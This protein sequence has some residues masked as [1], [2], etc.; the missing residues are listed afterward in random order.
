M[1]GLQQSNKSSKVLEPAVAVTLTVVVSV[2]VAAVLAAVRAFLLLLLLQLR[3]EH[4]SP[5]ET[6]VSALDV[7]TINAKTNDAAIRFQNARVCAQQGGAHRSS[8][9]TGNSAVLRSMPDAGDVRRGGGRK[10]G[11]GKSPEDCF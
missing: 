5:T 3:L 11:A 6:R 10:A 9:L 8:G 1:K 7:P 2:A 4:C